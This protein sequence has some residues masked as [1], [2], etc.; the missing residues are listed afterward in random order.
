MTFSCYAQADDGAVFDLAGTD[1]ANDVPGLRVA[2]PAHPEQGERYAFEIGRGQHPTYRRVV[3][4]SA[5]M[6]VAKGSF[7]HVLV[8][9]TG[10]DF[11]R[12]AVV[13]HYAR[14]VGLIREQGPRGFVELAS[15]R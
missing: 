6:A 7:Q 10:R 2:M 11:D 13:S 1:E 3:N 15:V 5:R 4:T 9:R 14:G 12:S 8:V